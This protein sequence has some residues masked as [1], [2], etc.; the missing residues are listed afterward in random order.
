MEELL[1][2][3]CQYRVIKDVSKK[4]NEYKAIKLIFKDYEISTPL[5]LTDDQLYIIR[6]KVK[7]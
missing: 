7:Q 6:E 1:R 3:Q 4:G 2:G 5:F